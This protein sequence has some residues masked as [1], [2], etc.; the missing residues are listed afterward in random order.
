MLPRSTTRQKRKP[1]I[2][3]FTVLTLLTSL[4]LKRAERIR[5]LYSKQI[6]Q[7]TD[8]VVIP[9]A[10]DEWSMKRYEIHAANQDS[11]NMVTVFC[12]VLGSVQYC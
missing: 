9:T 11:I 6:R 2:S 3:V 4:H 5:K 7:L 12:D 8:E 10:F 1:S